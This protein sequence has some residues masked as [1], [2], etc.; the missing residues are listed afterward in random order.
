MILVA[1]VALSLIAGPARAHVGVHADS[2]ASGSFTELTFRVPNESPTAGTTKVAVTLPQDKPFP[3]VSI[4]PVPGWKG[5][6]QEAPL[7][8]PVESEGTTIT[9]AARTVTWTAADGTRI[10]PGEYQEFSI[11]VG[12]LPATGQLMLPATQTYSDGK[13]VIWD[14]PTPASGEEPE[15]PAPALEVTAAN[16]DSDGHGAAGS[17]DSGSETSDLRTSESD[18]AADSTSASDTAARWLGGAALAVAL[19]ALA[20]AALTLIKA[21]RSVTRTRGAA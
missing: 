6:I 8:E 5:T 18:H 12:P 9:K 13:V 16:A 19:A 15:H 17:G 21:G 4:K 2:T 11:S 7:P 20:L 1:A 10:E 14:E 3:F